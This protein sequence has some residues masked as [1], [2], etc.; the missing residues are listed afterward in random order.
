MTQQGG[1]E[2]DHTEGDGAT[3]EEAIENV[4]QG[5][6]SD[7]VLVPPEDARSGEAPVEQIADDDATG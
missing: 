4:A 1:R 2:P 3:I 5:T 7:G 6:K